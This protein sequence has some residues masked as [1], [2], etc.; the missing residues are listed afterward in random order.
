MKNKSPLGLELGFAIWNE[1]EVHRG[2]GKKHC[3]EL[4]GVV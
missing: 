4:F 1:E 3:L 2:H